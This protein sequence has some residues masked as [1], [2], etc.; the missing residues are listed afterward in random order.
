MGSYALA[1]LIIKT[2]K[3]PRSSV[4]EEVSP[5]SSLCVNKP[6]AMR[7]ERKQLMVA[8]YTAVGGGS[9][10]FI[11]VKTYTPQLLTPRHSL[12]FSWREI[13]TGLSEGLGGFTAKA[14]KYY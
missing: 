4:S 10:G 8:T 5:N 11:S 9:R 7:T 1:L 12:S 6:T 14:L 2:H 13:N 3:L